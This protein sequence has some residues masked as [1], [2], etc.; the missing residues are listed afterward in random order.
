[1]H[2]VAGIAVAVLAGTINGLFAL[3]MKLAP[4]WSWENIWLPFSALGLVLFPRL[5]AMK[6]IPR[7]EDALAQAGWSRLLIALVWG[8]LIYS[9]SLMFG[10][11]MVYLGTAL[12]FALLVGSMSIVGVLAPI[13]AYSPGVLGAPGGRWILGGMAFLFAALVLCARA[14]ALKASAREARAGSR[15]AAL[16]GMALAISGGA[17][18]G[19]LSL[20]LNTGW[21]HRMTEA[22]VRVGGARES[23]A[24]N[25]VL[26]PV[27]A[28]GAIPN[29]LYCVYL[30]NR[31]DTWKRYRTGSGAYWLVVV[32]MAGMYS[33]STVLWGIST[34]ATMLGRLGP[35]VGWALFIGAIA[36]SSNIGGF[37]TGEWRDA[38]T[39]ARRTMVSGLALMV[40]AMG[41][42]GYGN[43]VLNR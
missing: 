37:L 19:L 34:S 33:G 24:A 3:P 41:L 30:L 25:A 15:R 8:I 1:M 7:L 18:S 31:N 20:G 38:G 17:L 14:G 5:L 10:R 43:L 9:G 26:I 23:V 2:L 6:G 16:L 29:C 11:S 40:T 28:G 36:V 4:R 32:L 13:L 42:V 22:A 27:L 35:S 12:A 21:A 39:R